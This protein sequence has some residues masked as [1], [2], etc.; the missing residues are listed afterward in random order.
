MNKKNYC[1][2][3]LLIAWRRPEKTLRIIEKIKE[4]NALKVYIAC[5]G[6]DKKDNRYESNII[7]TR[8]I[9]KEKIDWDCEKKYLFSKYNQGCKYAVSN[10][11]NWFFE[12]EK[13]G[14]ILEDDCL[15]HIDFFIFCEELLK[16]YRTDDRIWSITGQNIQKGKFFGENSY[17]FSKYSHCWG[18]A[19]WKRCWEKYDSEIKNWPEFKEAKMIENLFASKREINYWK[20]IFDNIYF[21]S[22]PDTWDYQ[23]TYACLV[24]SGLTIIPNK[25]LI[26][27]IG[28]DEEATHTKEEV[29]DSRLDNFKRFSSGLIPIK[30]P[31]NI[32]KSQKADRFT[33]IICY[34]GPNLLNPKELKFFFIKI[35]KKI[36][37]ISKVFMIKIQ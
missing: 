26:E 24:N 19:T 5:D 12:N 21:H 28:F 6:F 1:I 35:I 34:S 22:K 31:K 13:E 27:N 18:W 30:H 9:L 29:F 32:I 11:I 36:K 3:I 4:I 23:W 33:E 16:K 7:N 15:P 25:N 17:Y 8:K 20:R 2:P 37:K 10:A 14:I